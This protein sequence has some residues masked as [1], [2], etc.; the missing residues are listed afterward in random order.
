MGMI[1]QKVSQE[2]LLALELF[3]LNPKS[4]EGKS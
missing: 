1:I 4:Q 2:A 3:R